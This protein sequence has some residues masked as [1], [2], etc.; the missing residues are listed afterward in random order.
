MTDRELLGLIANQVGTLTKDMDMLKTS[1]A[2]KNDLAEIKGE[3]N[4]LE[5]NMATKNDLAEIKGEMAE[6]KSDI[7]FIKE[8]VIKI[9]NE[10]GQK[11][12]A[13]FDGYVMN[14]ERL[15][16]IEKEVTRHEEVILRKIQ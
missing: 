15:D 4:K 3:M 14:S 5:A 1:M 12:N 7:Q 11:L 2:T 9:E 6:V 8:T 13:L 16:R 10:Y